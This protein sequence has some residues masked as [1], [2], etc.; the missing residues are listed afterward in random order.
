M[1]DLISNHVGFVFC[2]M[3]APQVMS[4]DKPSYM[5]RAGLQLTQAVVAS[6]K[7]TTGSCVVYV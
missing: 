7:M 2:H 3:S 6:V 5:A 4:T 1:L